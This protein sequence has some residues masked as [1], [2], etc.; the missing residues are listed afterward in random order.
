MDELVALADPDIEF[1]PA[2]L[3][4]RAERIVETL[5]DTTTVL[6]VGVGTDAMSH[7]DRDVLAVEPS[8][9]TRSLGCAGCVVLPSSE[10]FSFSG[11]TPGASTLV[12]GD[13]FQRVS[14]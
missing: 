4:E 5:G 1:Y 8:G 9:R 11:M 6:N 7:F 2:S 14:R 12:G 13:Y 10:S 3:L